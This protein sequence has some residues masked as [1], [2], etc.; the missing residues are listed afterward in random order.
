ML[1]ELEELDV[2]QANEKYI[3]SVN[4]KIEKHLT[5]LK[6]KA[7][8]VEKSASEHGYGYFSKTMTYLRYKYNLNEIPK[9]IR[10]V[11][12]TKMESCYL[13]FDFGKYKGRIVQDILKEDENYCAWFLHE[14]I[15]KDFNTLKILDYLSKVF[16]HGL[17]T[18]FFGLPAQVRFKYYKYWLK[19]PSKVFYEVLKEIPE[20]VAQEALKDKNYILE[21]FSFSK[22][23]SSTSNSSDFDCGYL[24]DYDEM[25]YDIIDYGDL[26]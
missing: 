7:Y 20:K 8:E 26:C 9:W 13:Y 25:M 18:E 14:V 12:F 17:Q 21:T 19:D 5:E 10:A 11:I 2:K 16:Y 22:K 23:K 3:M 24:S 6:K 4:H 15:G 1:V